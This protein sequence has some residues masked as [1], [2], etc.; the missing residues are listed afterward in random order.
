MPEPR[1]LASWAALI[2]VS[3][4]LSL[5]FKAAGF[6]AAFLL[7]PML[8]A[9]GFGA[10]GIS[11]KLPSPAFT[12]A[13][14]LVG[15][16]VA[17][18]MT[19]ELAGILHQE[20]PL[21]FVAVLVTVI[22]GAVVGIALTRWQVLPGT[23][24][25]W[26]SAPGGAAAMVM[27]AEVHGADPRLVAF[28]QYLRVAAVVATAS[29]VARLL[30]DSDHVAAVAASEGP[31]LQETAVTLAVAVVGVVAA[32]ALRLP[33]AALVGPMLLGAGLHAAGY[34]TMALPPVVLDA[35]YAALGWYVGLRFTYETL[36]AALRALPAVV[37]ATFALILLCAAWA[38]GLTHLLPIDFLS[39]F[40]ATSPGGLDSVAIIAVSTKAD[41]SFVLGVQTLRL[42]VVLL[43][44]PFVAR[45]IAR[46]APREA[47]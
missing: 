47:A 45:R 7:G 4:V 27:M 21:I 1:I 41:I 26:G 29:V 23:T 34:V 39:A 37:A 36:R 33:S 9:I 19:P 13:Q 6:P 25:A 16:L 40:L 12:A 5:G 42:F 44:G 2:A 18:A 8:A 15:C 43:T 35:A 17:R 28:M 46:L 32:M 24:A 31:G 10:R 38:W 22:A 14:A 3:A 30:V 11:L 20:W